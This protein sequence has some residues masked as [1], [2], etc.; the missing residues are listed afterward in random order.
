MNKHRRV[1]YPAET[2]E[3]TSYEVVPD[4]IFTYIG[5]LCTPN[6]VFVLASKNMYAR[7]RCDHSGGFLFDKVTLMHAVSLLA[8]I[9]RVNGL[10]TSFYDTPD[11]IFLRLYQALRWCWNKE[12]TMNA[13]WNDR[14]RLRHLPRLL[15]SSSL[16]F[17]TKEYI[18]PSETMVYLY[19]GQNKELF[20][21]LLV[22]ILSSATISD[23]ACAERI[24]SLYFRLKFFVGEGHNKYD[25]C[26]GEVDVYIF[27]N[28]LF[29][30]Y[31]QTPRSA[32][33][34]RT[35][36][37][38]IFF[39]PSIDSI[40]PG[41]NNWITSSIA[42]LSAYLFGQDA[43]DQMFRLGRLAPGIHSWFDILSK[44]PKEPT[45]E[46]HRAYNLFGDSMPQM[47]ELW[48]RRMFSIVID[49]D[50]PL[51]YLSIIGISFI[52]EYPD[53]VL[54]ETSQVVHLAG[55]LIR[56]TKTRSFD[57]P[58]VKLFLWI[59][60]HWS[61]TWKWF[62]TEDKLR[63]LQIAS[64]YRFLGGFLGPEMRNELRFSAIFIG[65]YIAGDDITMED[66]NS[67]DCLNLL[68]FISS[69]Y[70]SN[71]LGFRNPDKV[72]DEKVDALIEWRDRFSLLSEEEL[73]RDI[74][75]SEK[76]YAHLL[77]E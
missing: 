42:L 28:A 24:A 10:L 15:V 5:R 29:D 52:F 14:V 63:L 69:R 67:G 49:S 25:I 4:D 76:D 18:H 26:G 6:F 73:C 61:D 3:Y 50:S 71:W 38:R 48:A 13:N 21:C 40:Y 72:S 54:D 77:V 27:G 68:R 8:S 17:D 60:R 58:W 37:R 11:S 39:P 31:L 66:I 51:G 53:S 33:R 30:A 47:L 44:P 62:S 19:I 56:M 57:L 7:S 34:F 1:E 35:I 36:L 32:N 43:W 23:D 20:K 64:K 45:L 9:K 41:K 65:D 2:I 22:D 12:N 16:L 59:R 75:E 55:K 70:T 74:R 46:I